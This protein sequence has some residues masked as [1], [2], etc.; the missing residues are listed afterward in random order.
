MTTRLVLKMVMII[1]RNKK[2]LQFISFIWVKTLIRL[3]ILTNYSEIDTWN[4]DQ[5]NG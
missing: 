5:K 3:S 1:A 2:I 4:I